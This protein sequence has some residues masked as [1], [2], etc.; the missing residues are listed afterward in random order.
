MVSFNFFSSSSVKLVVDDNHQQGQQDS[1]S[2]GVDNMHPASEAAKET[3][4][5]S[6]TEHK[7]R[8]ESA[9]P[10]PAPATLVEKTLST[11]ASTGSGPTPRSFTFFQN[12]AVLIRS[13]HKTVLTNEREQKKERRVMDEL[14]HV[15]LSD[16][17]SSQSDKRAKQSA[18]I[19]RS[20]IVGTN[21]VC[22]ASAKA[23][24]LSKT[25][26]DKVKSDLSKP[27]TASKVIAHLRR[28]D[29][30]SNSSSPT[31][32]HTY[33]GL[34]HAVCLY[35]SDDEVA[36]KHF[37]RLEAGPNIKPDDNL[38]PHSVVTA[39]L[40]SVASML[41]D[42]QV[43]SLLSPDLGIG[44]P[45]DGEGI[46]SGAVPTAEAIMKGVEVITPQL[47]SLVYAT[48]QDMFPDH[49]GSSYL[50]ISNKLC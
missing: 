48:G 29:I 43:L 42:L 2:T 4:Q 44:Q 20:L 21:V 7:A 16:S 27:K 40:E 33:K 19:V 13:N 6:L 47:L 41:S 12:R 36:R 39:S 18:E 35:A 37:S 31:A 22:L 49:K 34:I 26:L 10:S 32:P 45:A 17:I 25:R 50:F 24:P 3:P 9:D 46:L 14:K 28:L 38:K 15:V 11:S 5:A 8:S 23:K 30:T 1:S